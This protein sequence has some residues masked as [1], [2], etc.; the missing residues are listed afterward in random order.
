MMN[1][2][3][4][5]SGTASTNY[6]VNSTGSSPMMTNVNLT[7][8]AGTSDYG[9]WNDTSSATIQNSDIRASGGTNDGIHNV[10]STGTYLA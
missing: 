3:I 6:G 7:V 4:I 5:V 9:V 2:T 1:T 10:A 8:S